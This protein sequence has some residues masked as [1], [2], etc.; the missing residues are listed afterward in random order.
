MAGP[1]NTGAKP[2]LDCPEPPTFGFPCC[3]TISAVSGNTI[4]EL[5]DGIYSSGGTGGGGTSGITRA[6]DG[7]EV[8]AGFVKFAQT[9]GDTS[10]PSAF[11]ENRELVLNYHIFTIL[12]SN[13]N[14]TVKNFVTFY[15]EDTNENQIPITIYA[16]GNGQIGVNE[17]D[18]YILN[19]IPVNYLITYPTGY[20]PG[21]TI[22]MQKWVL[23]YAMADNNEGGLGEPD[24]VLNFGYNI[25]ANNARDNANDAAWRFGFETNYLGEIDGTTLDFEFHMPE[26]QTFNGLIY[27]LNSFYVNKTTGV[28]L[29]EVYVDDIQFFSSATPGNYPGNNYFEITSSGDY[30]LGSLPTINM[31]G[32]GL[33]PGNVNEITMWDMDLG[34]YFTIAQWHGGVVG[35]YFDGERAGALFLYRSGAVVM[36]MDPNTGTNQGQ[37]YIGCPLSVYSDAMLIIESTSQGFLPPRMTTIQKDAISSPTAGNTVYDTTLNQL[38]YYNGST[39]INV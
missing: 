13:N 18:P 27:R 32:D 34:S 15:Q 19:I 30:N 33:Q 35:F 31:Y 5:P 26:I 11:M 39:W 22:Q 8:I 17:N 25:L 28:C 36:N 10:D 23:A 12:D 3:T 6:N 9:S 14:A 1:Q 37:T 16:N 29:Q 38:S 7:L 21:D 4:V 2:C 24:A 20:A